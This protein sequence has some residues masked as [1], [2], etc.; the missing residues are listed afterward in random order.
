M[1]ARKRRNW[2]V[3]E[4]IHSG[5]TVARDGTTLTNASQS[6]EDAPFRQRDSGGKPVRPSLPFPARKEEI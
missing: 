2:G 4:R 3:V 6:D 5:F 1:C